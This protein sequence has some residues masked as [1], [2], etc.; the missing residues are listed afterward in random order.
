MPSS[1]VFLSSAPAHSISKLLCSFLREA[2]LGFSDGGS[3]PTAGLQHSPPRRC[4]IRV[5]IGS[6]VSPQPPHSTASPWDWG[7][8]A[9]CP[10]GPACRQPVA[11]RGGGRLL[12]PPGPA[13][14]LEGWRTRGLGTHEPHP[15][16][17]PPPPSPWLA[18][19]L[20]Q[21]SRLGEEVSSKTLAFHFFRFFLVTFPCN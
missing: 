8:F 2:F 18:V 9:H 12:Q 3:S 16:A 7:R 15:V 11:A 21:S 14:P 4:Q 1:D 17:P 10:Q 19:T 20:L 13:N 5:F 6:Y